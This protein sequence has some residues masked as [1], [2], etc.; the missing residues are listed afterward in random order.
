MALGVK[1]YVV[2]EKFGMYDEGQVIQISD[3]DLAD[4]MK[5]ARNKQTNQVAF[6]PIET[7][8]QAP[9]KGGVSFTKDKD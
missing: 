8:K 7:V 6:K 2:T 3:R 1:E 9:A 4:W 5:H